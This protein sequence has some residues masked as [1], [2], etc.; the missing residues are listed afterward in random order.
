MDMLMNPSSNGAAFV[1]S[2]R[3][4]VEQ[5]GAVAAYGREIAPTID[6]FYMVSCGAG[7]WIMQGMQW[8]ADG[9]AKNIEF[10]TF[11]SADFI[12]LNLPKLD[13]KATL[14]I[15][16]SESGGTKETLSA[17][18]LVEGMACKTVVFTKPVRSLLADHG[19]KK[20][21][22]GQTS[23]AYLATFMLMQAFFGGIWAEKEGWELLP[24]LLS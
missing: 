6:H 3:E 11:T 8:W 15:L 23:Q 17:A 20:F 10:R 14:V 18:K 21:F 2:L 7:H 13:N 19:H 4:T 1:E 16:S 22:M 5:L 24:K 12:A 9:I